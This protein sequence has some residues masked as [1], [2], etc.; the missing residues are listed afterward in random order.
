MNKLGLP[1]DEPI[2]NGLVS[3]TIESAQSKIEGYNFDL[4][5]HVLDY[6]DVMN[7]QREVVYKKRFTW[8]TM[9][10]ARDTTLDLFRDEFER[11][12][13]FHAVGEEG[14]WQIKEIVAEANTLFPEL[15]EKEAMAK[16]EAIHDDRS[17]TEAE[18]KTAITEYL[19]GEAKRVY[20]AK[21]TLIGAETWNNLQ[22]MLLLQSLDTL[23]MNHLDEIDYLR[24]GIGLRGYGQ[25]DPLIEY[26]R[27]AY[28]LFQ[29]LLDTVRKTY[30]VSLMKLTPTQPT[31]TSS[32][33][34]ALEFKGASEN[35]EQFQ[36]SNQLPGT[37]DQG[38]SREVQVPIH[39][40]ASI[41][42][43]DPCSCGSGLKWKKCGAINAPSH[44]Q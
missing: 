4:R 13:G 30:L 36:G 17:K 16:L 19:I 10:N 11:V 41:G 25:R 26:K 2:E 14:E 12:V 32:V 40:T 37:S 42:R 44:K 31:V 8:L 21:E 7:K 38:R 28:D 33:P 20:S 9:T 3:K 6:D 23:W 27:E 43:N 29:G 15:S 1:E 18:K 22:R 39:N 34:R 24:Q 5:K 35:I